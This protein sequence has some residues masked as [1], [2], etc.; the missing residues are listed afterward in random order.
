MTF[1]AMKRSMRTSEGF[2]SWGAIFFLMSDWFLET[3]EPCL[4]ARE[5]DV[6][7]ERE[8]LSF[9]EMVVKE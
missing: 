8:A 1:Q 4:L 7:R 5:M 3:V 9:I 6:A 2:R